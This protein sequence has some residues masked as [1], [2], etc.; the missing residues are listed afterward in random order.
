MKIHIAGF[1]YWEPAFSFFS[2]LFLLKLDYV[3]ILE[4]INL[5]KTKKR[6]DGRFAVTMRINGKKEFFYGNTKSEAEAKR[7]AFKQQYNVAPNIDRKTTFIDYLDIWLSNLKPNISPQTFTSYK[8]II[9]K[10]LIPPLGDVLLSDLQPHHFRKLVADM[11]EEGKSPRTIQYALGRASQALKQALIDGYIPKNPAFGIKSPKLIQRDVIVL[12]K[13]D[14]KKLF[15]VID[16][17]LHHDIVWIAL[18]TG[19]RREEILGLKCSD[20]DFKNSTISVTSVVVKVDEKATLV[21]FPKNKSSRRTISIDRKTLEL[22]S[23]RIN[24]T[25]T[26]RLKNG[27]PK[28]NNLIFCHPDGKPFLPN[29]ATVFFKRYVL[30]A[31]LSE[32]IT[33]HTLRHTHA[34]MLV[35]EKVHFKLI[36]NRLGHSNFSTTM[37]IYAH[38]VPSMEGEIIE[39]IEKMM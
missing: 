21:E 29:F 9:A 24:L 6:S 30:K 25:Q 16:N 1:R 32:E 34:T 26:D 27:Y 39:V 18:Y 37:D 15:S 2:P 13:A 8:N 14:I 3:T 7:D 4:V 31:G 23:N 22:L 5:P 17:D 11:V 10:H 12:S 35:K 20:V 38:K 33:F 36:Q 28:G 19:M